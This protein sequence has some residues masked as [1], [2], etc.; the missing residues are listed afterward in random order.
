MELSPRTPG[1][2]RRAAEE[3]KSEVVNEQENAVNELIAS[4]EQSG[5]IE[6]SLDQ[7][8]AGACR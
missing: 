7:P 2:E 5:V 6:V 4:M 8:Y 1:R 3:A